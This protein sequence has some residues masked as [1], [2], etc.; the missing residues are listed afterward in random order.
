MGHHPTHRRNHHSDTT[1]T[2]HPTF[3]AQQKI[4]IKT[5]GINNVRAVANGT[6]VYVKSQPDGKTKAL[7]IH[8]NNI[9]S[10]YRNLHSCTLKPEMKVKQGETIGKVG[11]PEKP[12]TLDFAILILPEFLVQEKKS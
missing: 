11:M 1:T 2:K 12:D 7:I 3:P 9:C 8:D 4:S 5:Q 6:V 10:S